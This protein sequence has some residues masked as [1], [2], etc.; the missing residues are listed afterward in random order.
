LITL[1]KRLR[2]IYAQAADVHCFMS[3]TSS[4]QGDF[5]LKVHAYFDSHDNTS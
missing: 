5:K 4:K 3:T 2:G 1:L